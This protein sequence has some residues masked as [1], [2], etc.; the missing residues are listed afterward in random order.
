M[1]RIQIRVNIFDEYQFVNLVVA[2]APLTF[3]AHKGSRQL[4]KLAAAK[5]LGLVS[6]IFIELHFIPPCWLSIG[7]NILFAAFTDCAGFAF[8]AMKRHE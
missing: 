6:T 1:I 7:G 3:A 2:A 4:A 5:Y 8:A